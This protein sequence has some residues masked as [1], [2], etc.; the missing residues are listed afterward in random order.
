MKIVLASASPRRSQLLQA[1][2]VNI[3]IKPVDI[4]ETALAG[5]SV[6]DMV[7]RLAREKARHSPVHD[8]PVIAA[9]TMVCLHD[10]PLGKPVDIDDARAMLLALSGNTHTVMTG[11]CVR[12]GTNVEFVCVQTSV[13]FRQLSVEEIDC[14]LMHNDVLD[15]AGAY[16]LQ[17]GAATF[18]EKVDGP[19]DN[20]IGLP[21]NI[22]LN[23]LSN[24]T[25]GGNIREH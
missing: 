8:R 4:D 11:V 16:A 3:E 25:K 19:L 14:Y 24:L 20:V 10:E 13:S 6:V 18:I 2:G 9:D 1:V 23:L 15:K 5:E 21:V 22:T 12:L 7:E 17:G